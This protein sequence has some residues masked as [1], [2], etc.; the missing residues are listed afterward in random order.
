V[1]M[2]AARLRFGLTLNGLIRAA[3]RG[4]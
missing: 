1:H 2:T 4:G 3:A